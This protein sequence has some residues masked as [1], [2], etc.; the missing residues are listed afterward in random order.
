MIRS[1]GSQKNDCERNAASLLLRKIKNDHH[2]LNFIVCDS[3][4]FGNG[5]H[6][7]LL[8]ELGY[9]FILKLNHMTMWHYLNMFIRFQKQEKLRNLKW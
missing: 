5:P 2:W 1:D 3:S 4:L 7:E 9:Q 6:I 8:L